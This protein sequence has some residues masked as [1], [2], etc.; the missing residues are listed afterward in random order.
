MS[1]ILWLASYPKSGNTWLRIM[2]ANLGRNDPVD[3]NAL[4][5]HG[6][7]ASAR[8]RFDNTFLFAAGL[9]THDECDRLRPALYRHVAAGLAPPDDADDTATDGL[10]A[11]AGVYP[12]KT[13]DAW[14]CNDLGEPILGGK[15]AACGAIL[16]VRDP[17]DVVASLANHNGQTLDEAIE[18]MARPDAE[19]ARS[20]TRQPQQLRQRLLDWSGFNRSWLDQRELPVHLLRYEDMLRDPAGAL[21]GVLDFV[22]A[23]LSD[24]A[25]ELAARLSAFQNLR[26]QEAVAGFRETP[27]RARGRQFFRQGKA[28]GWRGELSEAQRQ[29]VERE[30][31]AMMVRL[32]YQP[33]PEAAAS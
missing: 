2:L 4:Q 33:V 8:A 28:G 29:R 18:F 17:R 20:T 24:E 7:I 14:T 10:G 5:S 13:H 30:H 26:E 23:R 22:G 27:K 3:I 21:G 6:G 32:G 1:R 25:I 9:L 19:F 31:G 11:L 15:A 16:I 12:I